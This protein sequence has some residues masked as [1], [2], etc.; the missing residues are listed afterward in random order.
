MKHTI[1]KQKLFIWNSDLTKHLAFVFAKQATLPESKMR[2]SSLG[3][4]VLLP[5]GVSLWGTEKGWYQKRVC[6]FCCMCWGWL[7]KKFLTT[8]TLVSTLSL[9]FKSFS[10][11]RS[12]GQASLW[13]SSVLSNKWMDGASVLTSLIAS[14]PANFFLLKTFLGLCLCVYTYI[15][16]GDK[17]R[18]GRETWLKGSSL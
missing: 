6:K 18:T 9:G 10:L 1:V 8:F 16:L 4:W 11:Q 7:R 3:T 12:L 17:E 15:C 5:W 2:V 13:N 14:A